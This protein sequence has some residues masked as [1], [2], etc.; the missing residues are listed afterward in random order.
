[1][2]GH[3]YGLTARI[4][5]LTLI[6][7][8]LFCL[9]IA[10]TLVSFAQYKNTLEQV[11]EEQVQALM[12]STRLVQQAEGM[13]NASAMLF[14]AENHFNRRQAVFEVEDRKEWI[15]RL[16]DELYHYPDVALDFTAIHQ[17]KDELFDN[18]NTIN[19]LVSKRIN[20]RADVYFQE[21][22]N[23]DDLAQLELI[24]AEIGEMIRDNR[25]LSQDLSLAVGYQVSH[26]RS[27]M[28]SSV[29]AINRGMAVRETWL[30]YLGL[31]ALAGVLLTAIYINRSIVGRIVQLQKALS[32]ERPQSRDIPVEGRDEI[33]W[34]AKS[35]RRYVDKININESRILEMNTELS[36]LATH[37]A[38]TKLYNRHYFDRQLNHLGQEAQLKQ[39]SVA[40]I[41]IDF[42]KRINDS[43]GHNAGDQV[44]I[45]VANVLAQGLPAKSLLARIGGEEFAVVFQEASLDEAHQC[46]ERLRQQLE[47]QEIKISQQRIRVTVSMGLAGYCQDGDLI[48]C[49]KH[50]DAALYTAKHA[51]RNRVVRHEL[52]AESC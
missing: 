36:F 51:G 20:L 44:I 21:T 27:S 28:L 48:A 25:R 32:K 9:A 5:L 42:F 10:L 40:M 46:L 50:A 47:Q 4:A 13:V 38:L 15:E 2:S 35:I 24:Q 7:A 26:L 6:V 19:S 17:A 49:L 11:A 52:E 23:P 29:Q 1:M 33:A 39:F 37:D 16:I 14:L 43:H 34:M 41:D 8:L 22:L 18:L 12:V 3:G 30:L 31:L 45:E